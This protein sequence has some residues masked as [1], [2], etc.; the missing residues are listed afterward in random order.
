MVLALKM[1]EARQNGL[2][3][4]GAEL[5]EK[6]LLEFGD[7]IKL[8]LNPIKPV[9]LKPLTIQLKPSEVPVR[10]KQLRYRTHKKYFMIRYVREFL[11]NLET[12]LTCVRQNRYRP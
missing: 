9:N 5:L 4:D 2:S 12:S 11:K 1:N 7:V 3:A 6:M 8:K 10:A